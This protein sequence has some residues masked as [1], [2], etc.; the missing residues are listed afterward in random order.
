MNEPPRRNKQEAEKA[1]NEQFAKH[2]MH[3]EK[4]NIDTYKNK[5]YISYKD[6]VEYI[7]GD[8]NKYTIE[9]ARR[10]I[11]KRVRTYDVCFNDIVSRKGFKESFDYCLEYIDKNCKG[12]AV[13]IVCNETGETL[14]E[15]NGSCMNLLIYK[16]KKNMET[17]KLIELQK[18]IQRDDYKKLSS[19]LAQKCEELADL[20]LQKMKELEIHNLDNLD[21]DENYKYI[22]LIDYSL[23]RDNFTSGILNICERGRGKGN[24]GDYVDDSAKYIYYANSREAL[25]FI[26]H[27]NKYLSLL[28]EIETQKC[29]E[30]EKS[31]N[32]AIKIL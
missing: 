1:L 24:K 13:S 28:N 15:T 25:Y 7:K 21:A 8:I 26:N 23:F 14:I 29:I 20:I 10:E 6:Y 22:Y 5:V 27:F 4:L 12:R 30:I 18:V 11:H 3:D 19:N 2:L 31:I 32:K 9:D 17:E 16:N